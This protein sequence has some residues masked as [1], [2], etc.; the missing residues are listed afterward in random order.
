MKLALKSYTVCISLIHL[1]YSAVRCRYN[2]VNSFNNLHDTHHI[3]RQL[4]ECMG[5]DSWIE[6]Q[7]YILL[8]S[9]QSRA[10]YYYRFCDMSQ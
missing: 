7:I 4:W 2:A 6:T 9:L 1:E 3:A 8:R 5:Y 10:L